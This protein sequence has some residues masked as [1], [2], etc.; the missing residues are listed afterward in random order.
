MSL[1]LSVMP[2]LYSSFL[3]PSQIYTM[4]LGYSC[5]CREYTPS[6]PRSEV[7]QVETLRDEWE[8]LVRLAD[9]T[10]HRLLCVEKHIQERETERQ[11]TFNFSVRVSKSLFIFLW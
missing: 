7:V 5:W 1:G 10:H 6:L 11:V 8:G 3:T 2:S 9:S 4:M